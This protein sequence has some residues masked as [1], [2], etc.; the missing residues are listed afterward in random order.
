MDEEEKNKEFINNIYY[1]SIDIYIS[2]N[3]NQ[4]TWRLFTMI[5]KN[6]TN[7]EVCLTYYTI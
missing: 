2:N 5:Y 7:R 4:H 6:V 3:I 1:L